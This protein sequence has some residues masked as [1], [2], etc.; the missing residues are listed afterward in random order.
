MDSKSNQ[1]TLQGTNT[2]IVGSG[3]SRLLI[4]TGQGIPA[5]AKIV[6]RTLEE[7]NVSLKYVLLTHWHGDHT[8]GVPDLIRLYPHLSKAIYIN[9][10]S[11]DQLPIS[12]GQ[13][14]RVAGATI[15]ALHTP[16]H[17]RDHM[18]FILEEETAM[19]TGDNILGHGTTVVEELGI[20]MASLWAMQGECCT[21]GTRLMESWFRTSRLR[22]PANWR[23]K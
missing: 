17:S 2:Y 12:N 13:I 4:D 16:G 20:Y 18:S 9:S 23:K 19:F 7:L 11:R 10:P 3:S 15:R 8:E 21:L 1:F 14:F 6:S 5:W 22:S